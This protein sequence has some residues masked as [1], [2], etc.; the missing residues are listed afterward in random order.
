MNQ[1]TSQTVTVYNFWVTDDRRACSY[2]SSHKATIETIQN[3]RH[4]L[5]LPG[6]AQRVDVAELDG[7][8][9]YRRRATGWGVAEQTIMDNG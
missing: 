4:S 5:P 9:L 1:T 6:T 3:Q 2:M 7:D 8:N